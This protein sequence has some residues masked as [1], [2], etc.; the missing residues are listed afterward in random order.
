MEI[1]KK[2]DQKSFYIPLLAVLVIAAGIVAVTTSARQ[3]KREASQPA[4]SS[5]DA[6]QVAAKPAVTEKKDE[7]QTAP[8]SES[9]PVAEA[10]S[11]ETEA[12]PPEET[13]DAAETMLP[14]FCAPVSG[15]VVKGFSDSVPV[16]SETMND[17]R[18]H[19]GVDIVCGAGDAVLAAADGSIGAIWYD[20]LMG[21]CMTVVHSGEAATTYMGLDDNVPDGIAQGVTVTAGQT[22]GAV[23]DTALVECAEEPHLHFEMTISGAAVDP[24]LYVPF[25]STDGFEG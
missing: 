12:A 17:Y 14:A 23:G 9:A 24:C 15:F 1:K 16:Y 11:P 20:P 25:D 22:I 2:K 4:A 10:A 3:S 21:N 5:R 18:V 8:E 13:P 7:A 19:N 6:V